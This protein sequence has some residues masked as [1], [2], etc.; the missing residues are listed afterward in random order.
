LQQA[1]TRKQPTIPIDKLFESF[2]RLS[3]KPDEDLINILLFDLGDVN[4]L[5]NENI[6]ISKEEILKCIK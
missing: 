1:K 2:K 5:N 4:Q 6:N 3:K